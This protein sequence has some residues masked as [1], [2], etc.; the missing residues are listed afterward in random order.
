MNQD[1]LARIS[2]ATAALALVVSIGI[3]MRDNGRARARASVFLGQDPELESRIAVIQK[4]A[5]EQKAALESRIATIQKEAHQQKA[6]FD[7][8]RQTYA[9]MLNS[10]VFSGRTKTAVLDPFSKGF[11]RVDTQGGFLL[12]SCQDAQP[13]L[14]GYKVKLH[15]GNPLGMTFN[16]FKITARWGPR[17]TIT[18][19][20]SKEYFNWYAALKTKEFNIFQSLE[21]GRWNVVE[22]D[23][24]GT[25]AS[26]IGHVEIAVD[27]SRVVLL[28]PRQ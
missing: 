6:D 21:P 28:E 13:Y 11:G 26:Q 24:P 4:E 7:G 20:A 2:M 25:D 19:A 17:N 27:T 3:C 14:D 1:R 8:F 9:L 16:G 18:D 23:L 5:H 15:V 12:V 10:G 22:M